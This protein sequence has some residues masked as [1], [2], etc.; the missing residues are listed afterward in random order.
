MLLLKRVSHILYIRSGDASDELTV[1]TTA[2]SRAEIPLVTL[3][4]RDSTDGTWGDSVAS[5]LR[6][7]KRGRKLAVVRDDGVGKLQLEIVGRVISAL[8]SE[9]M[10]WPEMKCRLNVRTVMFQ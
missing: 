3:D 7:V 6:M 1:V 10:G 4:V 8:I 9:E 2:A 5:M